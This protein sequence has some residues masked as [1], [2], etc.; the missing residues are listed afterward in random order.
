MPSTHPQ[1]IYLNFE[2]ILFKFTNTKKMARR[3]DIPAKWNE[4]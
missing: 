4:E 1:I 2:N 3:Y